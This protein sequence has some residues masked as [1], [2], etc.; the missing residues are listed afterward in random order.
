VAASA[1]IAVV[2]C[3]ESGTLIIARRFIDMRM[4]HGNP[5][6]TPWETWCRLAPSA[7]CSKAYST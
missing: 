6:T 1:G 4:A 2:I 5:R 3:E 7:I